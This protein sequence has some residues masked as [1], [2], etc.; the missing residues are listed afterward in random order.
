MGKITIPAR[1]GIAVP[2]PAGKTVKVTN[3][4][5]TQVI[6]TWAF[7]LYPS[8]P[9]EVNTQMSMQ[10]TRASLCRVMIERGDGLYDNERR[11]ILEV[12][13]DF[14]ESGKGGIHDTLMQLVTN[15]DTR[16]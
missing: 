5:G 3:T 12:V 11:K 7:A 8:S 9:S 14:T 13:E 6:D 16:N 1:H 10:H 4:Y 2:L 15:S